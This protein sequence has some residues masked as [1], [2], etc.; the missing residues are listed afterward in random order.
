MKTIYTTLPIYNSLSKQCYERGRGAGNNRVIPIIT[1]RHRL[2]SFQW[3][4]GDDNANAII[5]I[6]LIDTA[7][8]AT[9]ITTYFSSMPLL[10]NDYFYY[11]G[12]SLNYLLPQGIYYLKMT[13]LMDVYIYY[14]EWFLVD[15][16]YTNLVTD[17]HGTISIAEYDTLTTSGMAITSAINAAGVAW[18]Q[19][20]S[21][22]V[23][24]GEPVKLITYLTN[25]GGELPSVYLN[26]IGV[27]LRSAITPM[28]AG[29][30]EVTLTPT[31]TATVVLQFGNTAAADWETT[32]MIL[33]KNYSSKY[34]IIDF[35]NTCDLG[36]IL[37]QHGFL[38]TL[39]YESE[40][41]ENSF[42]LEDRGVENGEGRF[43]RVFA[44]QVKKY[45]SR[46]KAMPDYMAEVFHRMKLH[47]HMTLTNLTGDAN[48]FFNLE[49]EHEWLWDDKY[50]ARHD[51]TFDYNE[52][53]GIGGCCNNIT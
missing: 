16:V 18:C 19:S 14:S 4:D 44:R 50:Y 28:V 45:L 17:P 12:D 34:L 36:D 38:Q 39:W 46:T 22:A 6:E 53:F 49:V 25:N 26:E 48:E 41:M 2:P 40:T 30:N 10:A 9:D 43:V 13:S 21:F 35:Y 3:L 1:P 15:C 20:N 23:R 33:F 52:A 5:K 29:Y 8:V 47:D 32:E 11:N 37:Y 7:G 24:T 51:L 42:P 31:A 27:S